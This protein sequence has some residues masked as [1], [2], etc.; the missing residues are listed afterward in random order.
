M[1]PIK[2]I[3]HDSLSHVRH[4]CCSTF[5]SKVINS[6]KSFHNF[7]KNEVITDTFF[8]VYQPSAKWKL[9]FKNRKAYYQQRS[10]VCMTQFVTRFWL[11]SKKFSLSWKLGNIT[12]KINY[13]SVTDY[14]FEWRLSENNYESGVCC[15]KI[16]DIKTSL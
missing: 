13:S 16:S 4:W 1:F 14:T 11:D 12:R 7:S 10:S 8:F 2:I 9:H 6:L 3:S 15:T 5:S